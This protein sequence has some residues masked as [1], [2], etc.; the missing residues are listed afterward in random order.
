MIAVIVVRL[1]PVLS[2]TKIQ[3]GTFNFSSTHHNN[4]RQVKQG[5]LYPQDISDRPCLLLTVAMRLA[6]KVNA[7]EDYITQWISRE[8]RSGV[9]A[10]ARQAERTNQQRLVLKRV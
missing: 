2:S 8:R 1:C 3:H 9:L 4:P 10:F 5:P 7:S 6:G